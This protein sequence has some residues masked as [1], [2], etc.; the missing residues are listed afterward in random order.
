M[1]GESKFAPIVLTGFRIRFG[2]YR[3]GRV[4]LFVED[5]SVLRGGSRGQIESNH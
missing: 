1:C 4:Y 2:N 3:D 5:V